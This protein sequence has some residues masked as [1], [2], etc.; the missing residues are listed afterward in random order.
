M[1]QVKTGVWHWASMHEGIGQPVHSHYVVTGNEGVVIDPRVPDEG[2]EW[3]EERTAPTHALLTNRHHYRHAERFRERFGLTVWCNENGM[4][5]FDAG[6]EVEPFEFGRQLPGGFTAVEVGV[7]CDEE[8]AYHRPESKLVALGDSVISWEGELGFVPDD[9]LGEDPDAVKTGLRRSLEGL[10]D[11][12]FDTLIL[13]H[14]EP[15]VS[16]ARDRLREFLR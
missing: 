15:L 13:A 16:D 14:G 12:D 9:Y 7:L 6:E 3:F 4:H 11:R 10:L 8:T 1:D 2:L 5:E